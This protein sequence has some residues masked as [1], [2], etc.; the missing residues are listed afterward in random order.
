MMSVDPRSNEVVDK[1]LNQFRK[2]LRFMS[3]RDKENILKEIE[4]H[5]YEKAESLGGI[6]DNNFK[7]AIMDFGTSK[8]ISK[9]YKEL[10]GYSK[11]FIVILMVIGFLLSLMTVPFSVP[12]LNRDLI[13]VNSICLGLSTI[14]TLLVFIFI[15]YV[16]MNFGKRP[17]ILVGSSCFISRIIMLS[18]L[19]GFANA[20][21]GDVAV[22]AG[23][24][25][26]LAFGMVGLFMPIV[27]YLAGRTTFSFK[28][29]FALEDKI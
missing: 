26:C 28:E 1:Y 14:F 4:S 11:M 27:G 5:L 8:E 23:G 2:D 29:G 10:Y 25:L 22:T 18:I 9:H 24:G 16:G 21:T 6:T 15:I 7:I 13:A 19:V 3:S 12:G 17:G 20:Q